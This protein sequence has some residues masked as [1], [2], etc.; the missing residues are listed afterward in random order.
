MAKTTC[1]DGF[2]L[3]YTLPMFHKC[4]MKQLQDGSMVQS[5]PKRIPVPSVAAGCN[6]RKN[7][8]KNL[9]KNGWCEETMVGYNCHCSKLT[10]SLTTDATTKPTKSP[11]TTM[12]DTTAYEETT[13]SKSRES[14]TTIAT[15]K[16]T[17]NPTTTIS[18]TTTY[19]ETTTSKS[20]KSL[21]T[22]ATTKPTTSHTTTILDTTTSQETTI[23]TC[24]R[25]SP[26]N[27]KFGGSLYNFSTSE[28]THASAVSACSQYGSHLVFIES[29]E[30]Q[31]FIVSF[32]SE[33][34]WIGLTGPSDSDART[35]TFPD[36]YP[37]TTTP[38]HLHPR[39][40]SPGQIPPD[41]YP[42]GQLPSRQVPP[43]TTIL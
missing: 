42:L 3:N 6:R 18:D 19:E 34:S 21:T 11:T 33:D 26:L 4:E 35:T 38:R 8:G 36:N 22:D 10:E 43:T 15:T 23:S 40:I 16:P 37:R 7:C 29:Q 39:T 17:T 1:P 25:S 27:C 28:M 41:N 31:D 30:E 32:A 13:T 5:I 9:C 2:G 14:S 12:S 24:S 20:S